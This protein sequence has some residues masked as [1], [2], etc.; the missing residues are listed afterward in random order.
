MGAVKAGVW[1]SPAAQDKQTAIERV[2]S[3]FNSNAPSRQFHAGNAH[4]L[5]QN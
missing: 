5:L 4:A 2:A 1:A 3:C